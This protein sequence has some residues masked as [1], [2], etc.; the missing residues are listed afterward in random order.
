MGIPTNPKQ[1]SQ[2]VSACL[3]DTRKRTQIR[4]FHWTKLVFSEKRG[5]QIVTLFRAS[6]WTP[7]QSS[8]LLLA[9]VSAISE[10][11]EKNQSPWRI[12]EKVCVTQIQ[13]CGWTKLRFAKNSRV[14]I[15]LYLSTSRLFGWPTNYNRVPFL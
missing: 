3:R 6:H 4:T 15:T 12:S 13:A 1:V 11:S 2:F 14:S 10:I 7:K 9:G 8:P 5:R